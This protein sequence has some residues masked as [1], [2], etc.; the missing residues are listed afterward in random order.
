MA[1]CFV[2]VFCFFGEEVT[3][4]FNSVDDALYQCDWIMF[5][6][7]WQKNMPI[8][9]ILAQRP[10]YIG[11]FNAIHCTRETFQKVIYSD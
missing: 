7:E 6:L 2:F 9:M 11:N 1:L 3:S 10:V 8:A 5:P 4:H